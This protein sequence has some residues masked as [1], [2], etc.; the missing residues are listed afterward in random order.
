MPPV[1]AVWIKVSSYFVGD[2]GLVTATSAAIVAALTGRAG[3]TVFS[4]LPVSERRHGMS[5]Q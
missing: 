4:P 3:P 1:I 5:V 2:E